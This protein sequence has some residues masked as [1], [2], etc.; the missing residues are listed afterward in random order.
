VNCVEFNPIKP[1]IVASCG[2]DSEVNIINLADPT[3]METFKPST[4]P[5]KHAGSDVLCCAWN[6]KVQHI[7]CSCSNQGSTVV[8]DLKKKQE[9]IC[10]KDP[11][12]RAR[13]SAVAW[14][15][16]VPTQLIVCYDDERNPSMQMWDL[17]N[18][19]Y[20][21]KEAQGHTKGILDI[22]WTGP[23]PNLFLTCGRDNKVICWCTSSGS[24]ETFCELPIQ[25]GSFQSRWA[26]H[27]PSIFAASSM[28][29]AVNIHSA[30]T[31][32]NTAVKYCPKWYG[33]PGGVSFGFGAKMFSF[34]EKRVAPVEGQPAAVSPT[35]IAS[36]CHSLIV[37]NEPEIVPTAD[38]FE[39]WIADRKLRDFC[40]DRTQRF[41]GPAQHEGL[42]WE[43]MG[44]RFDG[45]A[46]RQRVPTLLGFDSA[47]IEQEAEWYLGKK[48]GTTLMAPVEG[49][50][51]PAPVAQAAP[52]PIPSFDLSQAEDFF[53]DLA[54]DQVAKAQQALERE[55]QQRKQ[56]AEATQRVPSGPSKVDWSAGS[57]ALVKKS[58]LIGNLPAAVECCFKS[59]RMAEALLLAS[60]GGTELWMRARD[61]F[62]RIQSDP[63]LSAMGSIMTNDFDKLVS[64]SSLTNWKETLAILATYSGGQY[65]HLCLQLATR[66]E[67]EAFDIRSAAICYISAG[68]FSETARIWAQTNLASAGSKNLALQDLVEKMTVFQEA[69]KFNQADPLFNAKLTQYAEI[70]ANSGRLTAAMR[71]L[72]LLRDDLSS[73][74]LRER[75]YNSSP[76]QMNQMFGG[77]PPAFPFGTTDVRIAYTPPHVAA[78]TAPAHGHTGVHGGQAAPGG[79]HQQ[80]P[81]HARPPAPGMP[82]P[83]QGMSGMPRPGMPRPGMPTPGMPTPNMPGHG[84]GPPGHAGVPPG[85]AVAPA[86]VAPPGP[87]LPPRPNVGGMMGAQPNHGM[88][89]PPPVMQPPAYNPKAAPTPGA[90]V[91]PPGGG[92]SH[93]APGGAGPPPPGGRAAPPAQQNQAVLQVPSGGGAVQH[94]GEPMAPHDL[95]NV[96]STL[97]MLLDL[98]SQDGNARKRD[99]IA[100][101][102]EELYDKLQTGG[103]KGPAQVKLMAVIKAVEAQ[104]YPGANRIHQELSSVDWDK[105]KGWLM[106][107][108]RLIPMR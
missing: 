101:S 64:S 73:A 24:L 16:D 17:R 106:S 58:L 13:C 22:D 45:D 5:S 37:P 28:S 77:Q 18:A 9:V 102:L 105:N 74:I 34:G 86:A 10:F 38:L 33:K 41:G 60:G 68:N 82:G 26:P 104:D 99:A 11:A 61:E 66:L 21:F 19:Q 83:N 44:T 71:F 54:D 94:V 79:V 69:T 20:P 35:S 32:Q 78:A 2:A 6:R 51:A 107:L 15:P 70:L 30:Q 14:H 59:G 103:V 97:G 49:H 95:A 98:S 76:V 80:A 75:I 87:G 55:E 84:V 65:E 8:W 27:R 36:W 40:Q 4:G 50:T 56:E 100:K 85:H 29:G 67:K 57:E 48:P 46:G 81:G 3:K 96:K 7:L 39:R 47:T 89:A 63:F 88:A 43:L 90:H 91:L 53:N 31:Q 42:M 1:T 52:P 92:M 23:D 62:L 93:P 72:C 25:Q 12:G 108:K